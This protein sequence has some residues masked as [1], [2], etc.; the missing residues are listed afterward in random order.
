IIDDPFDQ[1]LDADTR[2]I[3][4]D[5]LP[6]FLAKLAEHDPIKYQHVL[7]ESQTIIA[8]EFEEEA[9][10]LRNV[11][12]AEKGFLPF[13]E[14]VGI[15]QPLSPDDL[16][17]R[18][19]AYVPGNA[20][21]HALVPV[22]LYPSEMLEAD[23]IFTRSLKMI[24]SNNVLQKIQTEFAGLANQIT[25]ADRKQ[26]KQR[27]ELREI[28]KK[29]CGYIGIGLEALAGENKKPDTNLTSALLQKFPVSRIFSVG[30]GRALK[31]KW[32]A[33]RWRKKSWFEN[34]HLPL[35]FWDE[36]WLGVLGGL[37]IKKP[38]FFDN[39]KTGILYR[40]FYSTGDV[41]TTETLL[42]EIIAADNI[43][44]LMAPKFEPVPDTLLTYKNLLLTLWA[45]H[46]LKLP[47]D[48]LAISL[49]A[50]KRFYDDLW[51]G[52]DIPRKIPRS[53]KESFLFWLSEQTAL[54]PDEITQSM[55]QTLENLFA[56]IEN[57]YGAVSKK[58]LDP[59]FIS[60][61]LIQKRK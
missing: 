44:S 31:L 46:Y 51:Y 41:K 42:D 21:I 4:E 22:P 52:T 59:R 28:V 20:D 50:F 18:H 60:L 26:I 36:E 55:G 16:K 27:E 17:S 14:A 43:F 8:G 40:D 58:A 56:E 7:L 35:S 12:L 49:E 45:K 34:R 11:R 57:E 6:G 37:L 48:P 10:R 29:A 47:E 15:Y 54:Q 32:R 9:Y 1:K 39:Y 5:F 19:P 61:F 25:A 33:E 23:T 13:E 3:N 24:A 53:M 38:M 2:K 30:Y